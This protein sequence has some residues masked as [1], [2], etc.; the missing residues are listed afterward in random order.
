MLTWLHVFNVV[1]NRIPVGHMEINPL[2]Q[3]IRI[4]STAATEPGTNLPG[5]TDVEL[6]DHDD[7]DKLM[8][9]MMMMMM[10]MMIM[11]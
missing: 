7:E 4:G 5:L 2:E 10:I 3:L 8:T 1:E 6:A 11:Q 9:G